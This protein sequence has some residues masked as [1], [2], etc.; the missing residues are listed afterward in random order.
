MTSWSA[1]NADPQDIAPLAVVWHD[2]WHHAH[3]EFVPAELKALRTLQEFTDRL[4]N[5]DHQF[6]T[7][8]PFGAPLGL[9]LVKKDELSQIFISAKAQG[10]GLADKLLNEGERQITAAGFKRGWL[11]CVKE[12]TRALRFYE[13]SG[14]RVSGTNMAQ[15]E[16][17]KGPFPIE[18]FI[19]EK[20][21][22]AGV[23]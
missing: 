6:I 17:S 8:G 12:N 2:A 19:L 5:P 10:T 16:T 18:T 22:G 23:D 9:C 15:L 21:F 1:R 11:D 3:D 7:A 4:N 13:R 20:L 14:W